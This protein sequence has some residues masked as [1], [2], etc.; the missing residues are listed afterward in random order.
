MK[1]IKQ[2]RGNNEGSVFQ[3]SKG[4]FVGYVNLGR[5]DNGKRKR[6]KLNKKFQD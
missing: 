3:N 6:K 2:R 1:K 4:L 5:D